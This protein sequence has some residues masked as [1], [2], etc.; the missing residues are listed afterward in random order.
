METLRRTIRQ[1][2]EM[3]GFLVDF[4][5]FWSDSPDPLPPI[6]LLIVILTIM[7]ICKSYRQSIHGSVLT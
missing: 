2:P 6:S 7:K 5:I 4:H 1:V 3:F